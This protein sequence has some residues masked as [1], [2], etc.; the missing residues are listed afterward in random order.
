[1]TLNLILLSAFWSGVWTVTKWIL[2]TVGTALLIGGIVLMLIY[3]YTDDDMTA[4]GAIFSV[5]GVIPCTFCAII[6][7]W[8]VCQ[9]ILLACL[10]G[11][12]ITAYCCQYK[13]LFY[14][15]AGTVSAWTLVLLMIY[16]IVP[17][18][19]MARWGLFAL[20]GL[21][22]FVGIYCLLRPSIEN[23]AQKRRAS[24]LQELKK[25]VSG[26]PIPQNAIFDGKGE[27][28]AKRL[29]RKISK[30]NK[31][32]AITQKD[33]PK[34]WRYKQ[35]LYEA[36]LDV[37]YLISL[38]GESQQN[39]AIYKSFNTAYHNAKAQGNYNLMRVDSDES[40]IMQNGITP[41]MSDINKWQNALKNDKTVNY[42]KQI[43]QIKNMDVSGLFGLTSTSK[44]SSQTRAYSDLV[45]AALGEAR[46]LAT[47]NNALNNALLQIRLCAYRNLYLGV[48]L[49][50]YLR[51]NTGGGSL[52]TEHSQFHVANVPM[53]N[54]SLNIST[55]TIDYNRISNMAMQGFDTAMNA[56]SDLGFEP[57][58]GASIVVGSIAAI[59]AGIM[60]RASKL[61][62]NME[63]QNRLCDALN[64]IIP[65][66]QSGQAGL[67]R[68]IE[69][70]QAIV[71]ANNGFM[72]IY[73]P[74]RDKVFVTHQPVSVIDI[75]A[76]VQATSAY[77]KISNSKI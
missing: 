52:T 55:I 64:R 77:N 25:S 57:G 32:L 7:Y 23:A 61:S 2:I 47:A 65:Q 73:A 35:K 24:L 67:L 34:H 1:M 45:N 37:F 41:V 70:M 33:T 11:V 44:L 22:I 42:S 69:V 17:Y 60:E 72:K 16:V 6:P 54:I 20:V 71:K 59:G 19:V 12:G 51:E 50:N 48:E 14:I 29:L 8:S 63:Q 28:S 18:W 5:I 53:Q 21:G 76:L 74:I 10:V 49:L 38:R 66:I 56:L 36:K 43:K 4:Q 15:M 46:E 62:A 30:L 68:T 9:W 26:L 31:K 39:L 27:R 3:A 75:N 58:D 13:V 40:T